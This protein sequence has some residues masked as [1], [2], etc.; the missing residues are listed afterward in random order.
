MDNKTCMLERFSNFSI[1]IILLLLSVAFAIIS[2][3]L[4]PV[5]GLFIAIP[6]MALG[7]AFLGAGR[8]QAC[9]LITDRTRKL[10]T[11]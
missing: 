4:M 8:S 9:R 5:I 11:F 6:V 10:T 7:I 1:G 3:V 2:F